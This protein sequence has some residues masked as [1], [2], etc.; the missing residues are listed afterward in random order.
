M[1]HKLWGFAYLL[2]STGK[3]DPRKGIHALKT[4]LALTLVSIFYYVRPLYQGVAGSSML[5]ITTVAVVFEFDVGGTI[6]RSFNRVSA[7]IIAG[8]L[9][10]GIHIIADRSTKEVGHI[11]HGTTVFLIALAATFA[12]FIPAVKSR[13]DY[14]M[15]IFIC[16]FTLITLSGHQIGKLL[17][18]AIRRSLTIALGSSICVLVSM[19]IYPIWAGEELQLLLAGNLHKLA[20]SLEVFMVEYFEKGD[21]ELKNKESI[22]KLISG[23]RCVLSSKASEDRLASLARW[24][25]PHGR[26]G[27]KHPWKSYKK[28]GVAIRYSASCIETLHSYLKFE[29]NIRAPESIRNHLSSAFMRLCFCSSSTL[30][31]LMNSMKEMKKSSTMGDLVANMNYAEEEL[32][33]ALKTLPNLI[34]RLKLYKTSNINNSGMENM[35]SRFVEVVPLVTVSSLLME[36]STRIK[37]INDEFNDLARDIFTDEIKERE[38]VC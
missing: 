13:Y 27:I 21:H 20:S 10:I 35:S 2:W 16:T 12:R 33:L 15:L 34:I 4:A 28:V 19:V 37:S 18:I 6:Y 36:I 22:Q 17:E 24:E 29:E 30:K 1:K 11:V 8:F 5:S 31:E 32:Q 9:A 26:F 3:S 25:P 23:Y 38:E 7:T 14:G